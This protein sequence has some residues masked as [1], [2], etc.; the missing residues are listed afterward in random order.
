[1]TDAP[2]EYE[3][4]ADTGPAEIDHAGHTVVKSGDDGV[5][6]VFEDYWGSAAT[7]RYTM[8]DGK[9]WFEIKKMNEGDRARYQYEAALKMTTKRKS[10]DT[11][12]DLD[13]AKDRSALIR[14]SVIGWNMHKGGVPVP[15]NRAAL[16]AWIVATEPIYIDG[17]IGKIRKFNPFLQEDLSAKDLR[18]QIKDLE[19]ML[20]IA[21]R[22]E[23]EAD[24]SDSK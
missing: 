1:M 10:G 16:S 6:V 24:F 18:E 19:E 17:L 4:P 12:I 11:E 5:E 23:A 14:N 20:E 3:Y 8:P 2:P 21:L 15:F 22:R 13:Q 7:T 9:Q